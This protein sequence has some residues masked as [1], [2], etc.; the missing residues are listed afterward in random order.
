MQ[1]FWEMSAAG[2]L[3]AEG[4]RAAAGTYMQLYSGGAAFPWD[5]GPDRDLVCANGNK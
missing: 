3:G 2:R 4:C 5:R 1:Q